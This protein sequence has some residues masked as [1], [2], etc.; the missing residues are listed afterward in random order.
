MFRAIVLPAALL[1]TISFTDAKNYYI[2]GSG[3]DSYNGLSP[4]RGSGTVGPFASIQKAADTTNPGDTVFIMNGTYT[5]VYSYVLEIKR[6]GAANN[7]IVYM[8]YPG[9]SPRLSHNGWCGIKS[10]NASYIEINGLEIVGNRDNITLTYANA[11]PGTAATSGGGIEFDGRGQ[12]NHP[13]HILIVNNTISRCCGGGI[14]MIQCDYVTI[15]NNR[16]WGNAWYSQWA[17]SGI[18]IYQNWRFDAAT[19]YKMLITRNVC[20]DNRS[21]VKWV[22]T[23]AL[24]D[25]NGIIIDDSKNTQNSSTLGAYTG[26]TL[27]TNNVCFNNGGS[28]IHSYSSEHVDIINNTTYFNGQIVNYPNCFANSSADVKLLNNI[29]YAA[30][31][32]PVNDNYQN[33]NVTYDYNIYYGG[34]IPVVKGPHDTVADPQFVKADTNASLADFRLNPASPGIDRGTTTGAPGQDIAGTTRPQGAGIDIGAYEHSIASASRPG[35]LV[36]RSPTIAQAGRNGTF[37]ARG[38]AM[39]AANAAAGW[40]ILKNARGA[41]R[42]IPGPVLRKFKGRKSEIAF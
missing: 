39:N 13:H 26:R 28:G 34:L 24:S 38:R 4:T 21:L 1:L 11:N 33:S 7:W 17:N 27:V 30:P 29:S 5:N 32:K 42:C 3:S 14:S 22:A 19:G 8:A 10:A 16:V 2:S 15:D 41:I 40:Q 37:D 9:H 35:P 20:Y 12:Q 6:S 36:S 18:S 25:G 23:N 31:G